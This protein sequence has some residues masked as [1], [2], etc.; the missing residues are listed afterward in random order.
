MLAGRIYCPCMNE[1]QEDF[2]AFNSWDSFG[3]TLLLALVPAVMHFVFT[4]PSTPG[5]PHDIALTITIAVV[6]IIISLA[7]LA[8]SLITRWRIIGSVVNLAGAIL[9]PVY[10]VIAICAWTSGDEKEDA[11][12]QTEQVQPA[13]PQPR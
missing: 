11:G 9:T 10:V 2:N 7:V 1:E 4:R 3:A 5:E 6:G 8:L 12:Q 13:A